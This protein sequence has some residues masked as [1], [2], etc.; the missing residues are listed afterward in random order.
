MAQRTAKQSSNRTGGWR[1]SS[2]L[3]P[4]LLCVLAL[5]FIFENRAEAQIR[6]IIPIITMPLWVAL[7]IVWVIGLISGLWFASRRGRQH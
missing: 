7:L 5:V 3:V 2:W 4:V 6:L 1:H